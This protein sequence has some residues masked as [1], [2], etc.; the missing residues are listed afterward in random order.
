MYLKCSYTDGRSD[1]DQL[2]DWLEAQHEA[3]KLNGSVLV[4]KQ[5]AVIYKRH[6]GCR[7]IEQIHKIDDATQFN[8]AS[9]SKQFTA[10]G[11][12]LLAHQGEI[13]LDAPISE[14]L[15]EFQLK[16]V[17]TLRNLLHHQ[18]GFK[19]YF[20]I[21]QSTPS[22]ERPLTNKQAVADILHYHTTKKPP[23]YT[24]YKYSNSGY[25]VLAH[26]IERV[27]GQSFEQF[28][29]EQVFKTAGLNNTRVYN[30]L[31]EESCDNRAIG[32]KRTLFNKL[33]QKDL[34]QWDAV[35]GDGGVYSCT[36]D[37]LRWHY[38]LMQG[39]LLPVEFY[40]QAM[41]PSRDDHSKKTPYGFGW[42]V[43]GKGEVE[44]AGGWQGFSSYF[45]RNEETDSTIIILDNA[46]HGFQMAPLGYR[47]NSLSLNLRDWL[48]KVNRSKTQ[49]NRI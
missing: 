30:L 8:L 24:T 36:G 14:Y 20:L 2:D 13:N 18:G 44:H 40:R 45:Y 6:F 34:N 43:L 7:D 16:Q 5:G 9:V 11:I 35:A 23:K 32:F 41:Q 27:S 37:L 42:I 17:P 48:K 21:T 10:F 33:K 47:W 22:L 3:G 4:S 29:G 26:I 31:S 49:G 15:P 28:M 19:E 1:F 25:I 46:N 12:L 39:N 38:S